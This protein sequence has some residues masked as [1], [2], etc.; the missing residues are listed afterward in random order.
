MKSILSNKRVGNSSSQEA[1]KWSELKV[2]KSI[3]KYN[4]LLLTLL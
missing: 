4:I 3:I 1:A 2:N